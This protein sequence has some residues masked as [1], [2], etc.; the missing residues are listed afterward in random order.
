[1]LLK[2]LRLAPTMSDAAYNLGLLAARTDRAKALEFLCQAAGMQG[3][4]QRYAQAVQQI[5]GDSDIES[6][7]AKS[8][9]RQ[10]Q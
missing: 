6:A 7:C 5:S 4:N 8:S 10:A 1:M 9:A 2:A 3:G